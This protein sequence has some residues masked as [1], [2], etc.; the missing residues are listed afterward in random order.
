MSWIF[1][2]PVTIR[3]SPN[4]E[5]FQFNITEAAADLE[6]ECLSKES[7]TKSPNGSL[8]AWDPLNAGPFAP[9]TMQSYL[10]ELYGEFIRVH[11]RRFN[12]PYTPAQL[13][14]ATKHQ[15]KLE[16]D[17]INGH[18]TEEFSWTFTPASISITKTGSFI[19]IWT[20]KGDTIKIAMNDLA[21]E[22][23]EISDI[24]QSDDFLRLTSDK[25]LHDRKYIEQARLRAKVAKFKAEKAMSRYL[26]KYGYDS[27]ILESD[28][29]EN[30]DSDSDD[31][32]YS[33]E[34]INN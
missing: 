21:D 23:E 22:L 3:D 29:G 4:N 20:A 13:I 1:T 30:S 18:A 2:A 8:E 10:L 24:P 28:S 17:A 7:V 19:L 25:Q 27:D 6:V 16:G 9:A 5:R 26:E 33:E 15:F 11:G 14:K 12:K 32:E 31:S 34:G